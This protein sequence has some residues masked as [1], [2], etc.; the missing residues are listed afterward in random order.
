M[1]ADSSAEYGQFVFH[2]NYSTIALPH[3]AL[4]DR[5]PEE[6]AKAVAENQLRGTLITAGNSP[7]RWPGIGGPTTV[8][9][10]QIA[11]GTTTGGRS[12]SPI[13]GSLQFHETLLDCKDGR[14]VS[15][16]ISDL[17]SRARHL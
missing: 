5:T 4:R 7:L 9:L 11:V 1:L 16:L 13:A 8:R 10:T 6:F 12:V 17:Y 15:I 2:S 3:Q 14:I